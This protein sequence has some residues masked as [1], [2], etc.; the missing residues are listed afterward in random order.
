MN[1]WVSLSHWTKN[2]YS[3]SIHI[4]YNLPE[5]CL[6]LRKKR[7]GCCPW[8]KMCNF[9]SSSSWQER[10]GR[11][12]LWRDLCPNL[13]ATWLGLWW[14]LEFFAA[15]RIHLRKWH[16]CWMGV[17][18]FTKN[19]YGLYMETNMEVAYV[20]IWGM[21]PTFH[22]DSID[23]D[24][25]KLPSKKIVWER[26]IHFFRILEVGRCISGGSSSLRLVV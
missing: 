17:V 13:L 8:G 2:M 14:G 19:A 5:V 24:H 6:I 9:G 3:N 22:S 12:V 10:F 23:L 21:F 4:I 20:C 26:G 25:T 1:W 15:G 11:S 7:T 16:M 18:L